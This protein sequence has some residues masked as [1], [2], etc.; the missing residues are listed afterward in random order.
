MGDI[1]ASVYGGC[2]P[3]PKQLSYIPYDIRASY[4]TGYDSVHKDIYDLL[5]HLVPPFSANH[6]PID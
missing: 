6:L 5:V 2:P 4:S 1:D 3:V